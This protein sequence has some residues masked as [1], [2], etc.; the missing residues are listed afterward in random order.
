MS[1]PLSPEEL[2]DKLFMTKPTNQEV[3][4]W[5]KNKDD[6]KELSVRPKIKLIPD[7]VIKADPN[8]GPFGRSVVKHSANF[9]ES[10][11][12]WFT[13]CSPEPKDSRRVHFDDKCSVYSFDMLEESTES[14]ADLTSKP[15]IDGDIRFPKTF[16]DFSLKDNN[17]N[18]HEESPILCSTKKKENINSVDKLEAVSSKNGHLFTDG[19]RRP[20]TRVKHK[21]LDEE[22]H[23]ILRRPKI[24]EHQ[25]FSR[26][27]PPSD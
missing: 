24:L 6:V 2:L 26:L 18:K 11:A 12:R 3:D 20:K 1:Q 8:A 27:T 13:N 10:K 23:S 17:N 19:L 16:P 14:M 15:K 22:N 5:S 9:E 4:H 25:I 7:I 21:G